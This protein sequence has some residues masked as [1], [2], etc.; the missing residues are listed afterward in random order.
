[1]SLSEMRRSFNLGTL[2]ESELTANP[3]D[4]FDTWLQQLIDADVPDPTVFTLATVSDTGVPSQRILLLKGR[5]ADHFVFYTNYQ[6]NKGGDISANNQVS[7]HFP[8]TIMERQVLVIGKAYKLTD[9]QNDQY[10][11]E[12]PK[13]SQVGAVASAQ[14]QP[15]D[16]RQPLV[17]KFLALSQEYQDKPVP[18][19]KHW[20]GYYVVPSEIEF[21]QGGEHRLHDRFRYTKEANDNW[22]VTRLN[23]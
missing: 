7:L 18:R 8:W 13:G 20:G 22:A 12:R 23:P 17:D 3:L 4:L 11:S 16:S 6:S 9:E 2:S 5:P 15:L 21:W 14:S 10:F 1:M 19:P